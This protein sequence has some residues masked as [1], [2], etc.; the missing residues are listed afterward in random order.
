VEI[1]ITSHNLSLSSRSRE[2]IEK[3]MRVIRRFAGDG[4]FAQVFLRRHAGTVPGRR[5]SARARLTLPQGEIHG[6]YANAHLSIAV[7]QL[8]GKFAWQTRQR[9]GRRVDAVRRIDKSS[10]HRVEVPNE[11]AL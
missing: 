7:R 2:F 1:R 9:K 11:P 4:V 10:H 3:K 5:F 6:F 8:V